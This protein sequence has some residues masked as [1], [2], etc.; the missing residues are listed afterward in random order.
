MVWCSDT[1]LGAIGTLSCTL[2]DAC[3]W[4]PVPQ[5]DVALFLGESSTGLKGMHSLVVDIFAANGG[6]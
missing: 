6:R 5:C 4:Q 3:S 2:D 1:P